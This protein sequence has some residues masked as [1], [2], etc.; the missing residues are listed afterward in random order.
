MEAD[1]SQKKTYSFVEGSKE[2]LAFNEL[3]KGNEFYQVYNYNE[4]NDHYIRSLLFNYDNFA[5][6]NLSISLGKYCVNCLKE[7][8]LNDIVPYSLMIEQDEL[9]RDSFAKQLKN[10]YVISHNEGKYGE[11]LKYLVQS[12]LIKPNNNIKEEILDL[13]Y[14]DFT[15]NFKKNV[16]SLETNENIKEQLNLLS[17]KKKDLNEYFATYL[18]NKGAEFNHC[19][20]DIMAKKYIDLANLLSNNGVIISNENIANENL[21]ITKKSENEVNY[22]FDEEYIKDKKLLEIF[23]NLNV[24]NTRDNIIDKWIRENENKYNKNNFPR[25]VEEFNK[26][27]YQKILEKIKNKSIDILNSILNSILNIDTYDNNCVIGRRL[28][29]IL[30]IELDY[31]NW[32]INI[33]VEYSSSLYKLL[34]KILKFGNT[35][36]ADN[37]A[38]I[39]I[40]LK[41]K[42]LKDIFDYDYG[43]FVGKNLE[44]PLFYTSTGTSKS[45]RNSEDNEK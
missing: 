36:S 17:S 5:H 9:V 15:K 31:K 26:S 4:A 29:N 14:K 23:K 45:F 34:K 22:T 42:S 33:G 12:H 30:Y 39:N 44:T 40:N 8:K 43:V 21:K 35:I 38:E 16:E 3:K 25:V 13:C 11:S 41:P 20:K 6:K 27:K 24:S 2:H 7:K 32:M 18:N 19:H 37:Y 28:L 10:E 1:S